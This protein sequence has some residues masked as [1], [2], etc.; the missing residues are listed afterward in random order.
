MRCSGWFV[1]VVVL[2]INLSSLLSC[3]IG[4]VLLKVFE[5]CCSWGSCL[6]VCRVVSLVYVK[7]LVN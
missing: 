6:M 7:F 5:C 1:C 4:F 3:R 2:L